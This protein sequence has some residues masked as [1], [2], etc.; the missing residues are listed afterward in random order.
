MIVECVRFLEHDPDLL[1]RQLL[2]FPTAS[3]RGGR[4]DDVADLSSIEWIGP[5]VCFIALEPIHYFSLVLEVFICELFEQI[6]E[7]GCGRGFYV[8]AIGT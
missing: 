4:K 2:V 1:E 8:S 5:L 6:V 3:Q 7:N